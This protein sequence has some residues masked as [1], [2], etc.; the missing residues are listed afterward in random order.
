MSKKRVAIVANN[1][2]ML[3]FEKEINQTADEIEVTGGL[4]LNINIYFHDSANKAVLI[5]DECP[6]ERVPQTR[7]RHT[8]YIKK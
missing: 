8:S 2:N 5:Y 1:G 4:V 3:A 6:P 7:Y